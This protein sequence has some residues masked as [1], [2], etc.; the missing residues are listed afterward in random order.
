MVRKAGAEGESPG[1]LGLGI[2]VLSNTS[3]DILNSCRRFPELAMLNQ[4]HVG[5][6]SVLLVSTTS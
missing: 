4:Q 5:D 3:L 1:V 6:I 2:G